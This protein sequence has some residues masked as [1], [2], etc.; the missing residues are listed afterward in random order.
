MR[1]STLLLLPL[2][3][4]ASLLALPGCGDR[5]RVHVGDIDHPA[6]EAQTYAWV[7]ERVEGPSPSESAET[8]VVDETRALIDAQLAAGGLRPAPEEDAALLLALRVDVTREIRQFDPYFAIYSMERYE[9]GHLT[10]AALEPISY[11]ELWRASTSHN[12]RVTERAMSRAK[13]KWEDHPEERDWQLER[14]VGDV[15]EAF[16]TLD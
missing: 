6:L 4:V 2:V 12:L 14:M 10:F 13:P 8:E 16:P 11:V 3:L 1:C 9:K 15:L 7:D 5:T